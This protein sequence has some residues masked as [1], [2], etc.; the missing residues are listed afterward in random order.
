MDGAWSKYQH[1]DQLM[2][3]G[4][5]RVLAFSDDAQNDN[6]LNISWCAHGRHPC[7]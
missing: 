6:N 2:K 1:A 4:E 5:D 7:E 3:S